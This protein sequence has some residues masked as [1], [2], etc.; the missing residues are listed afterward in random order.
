MAI[1]ARLTFNVAIVATLA[2]ALVAPPLGFRQFGQTIQGN[3]PIGALATNFDFGRAI[4]MDDT[5]HRVAVGASGV[6][7]VFE[8]IPVHSNVEDITKGTAWVQ[9]FLLQ[10][11]SND[12]L[13]GERVSLSRD[14]QLI[15]VRINETVQVYHVNSNQ[16]GQ[17]LMMGS[18]VNVCGDY[19]KLNK[20]IV[21]GKS[22]P[23]SVFGEAYWLVV[24][25]ETFQI[26]SG[27]VEILIFDTQD[28]KPFA[29]IMGTEK[30]GL[31]GWATSVNFDFK[32]R[33]LLAISSPNFSRRR[34]MVQTFQ[35]GLD[36]TVTQLG[37]SLLGE[38][39]GDQF[40]FAIALS[41]TE[42]PHL[43][44]GAPQA[45]NDRG[46]AIIYNWGRLD[47]VD[48]KSG[49]AVIG[50]FDGYVAGDSLGRSVAI[51][52]NGERIVVTSRNH[53]E[54]AGIVRIFERKSYRALIEIGSFEEQVKGSLFG[55]TVSMNDSGSII[56]SGAINSNAGRVHLFLDANPFCG[57]VE[58]PG[59]TIEDMFLKRKICRIRDD[60]I[61]E[62]EKCNDRHVGKQC[63]WVADLGTA[64]PS[65]APTTIPSSS[66]NISPS[67]A[68]ST[69][70][71][72]PPS[73]SPSNA[74]SSTPSTSA[75]PSG[76]RSLTPSKMPTLSPSETPSS[77]PNESTAPSTTSS[78]EPHN[79]P[80]T[81]PMQSDVPTYN[82][83][84]SKENF[85]ES[86][87]G[88]PTLAAVGCSFA[89]MIAAVG[90]TWKNR[91][92]DEAA[93]KEDGME[94]PDWDDAE[95]PH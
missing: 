57:V 89:V 40:G 24:S 35:L 1:I 78:Y 32:D 56:A 41:S 10:R 38:K 86:S 42:R 93:P 68:P 19:Q 15:A 8:R 55:S 70:P 16:P 33:I 47:T 21:L 84:E 58:Y 64:T 79:S 73:K 53:N 49:W 28:W 50:Q 90:Y 66:P 31:F 72:S 44:V 11:P 13:L 7:Q 3:P 34:G 23:D 87:W 88:I 76:I 65:T 75:Q 60:A 14:G 80:S 81:E 46:F 85:V 5:G 20:N 27:K 45:K 92:D 37:D 94:V 51:S 26:H 43:V 29:T 62:L 22:Q 2:S 18:P 63:S 69:F 12:N 39:F 48:S 77:L 17:Q 54:M 95:A 9:R 61:T 25:C 52:S 36:G 6:V 82:H 91:D 74:P 59:Q 83:L 67:E 30:Q 71:S 4:D